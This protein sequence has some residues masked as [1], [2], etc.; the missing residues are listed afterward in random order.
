MKI[1]APVENPRVIPGGSI[2]GTHTVS[3][4][5]AVAS[6]PLSQGHWPRRALGRTL[7]N[8]ARTSAA[9]VSP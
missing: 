3:S 6:R 2:L 5:L 9:V 4:M 1:C 8:T 7:S